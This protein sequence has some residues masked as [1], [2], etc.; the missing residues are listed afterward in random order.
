M[1]EMYGTRQGL[2]LGENVELRPPVLPAPACPD[3]PDSSWRENN[4]AYW[5][6]MDEMYGTR[7]GLG[8]G[9]NVELSETPGH[10]LALFE[11]VCQVRRNPPK[12]AVFRG[13]NHTFGPWMATTRIIF[14]APPVSGAPAALFETVCQVRRNPPKMAVFRGENHTFGPWMATTRII[15]PAPPVSGA[16]AGEP[17]RTRT[18]WD[19]ATTRACD[20]ALV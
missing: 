11:T 4:R 13:E 20:N 15:F 6:D 8:L 14:P 3:R 7:Q 12:M 18:K 19:G 1:D 16:P 17:A 10:R 9:E 5:P 2:G